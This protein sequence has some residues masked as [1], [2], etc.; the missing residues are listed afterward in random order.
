NSEADFSAN[1]SSNS[2]LITDTAANIRRIVQIVSA[3]DTH[4]A[5]A[6]DYRVL[7]LQYA[8]ATTTA[9]LIN[10]L[11]GDQNQRN[12][13]QGGGGGNPFFGG[14]GGFGGGGF[15]GGGFGGGGRGGGGG[16]GGGGGGGGNRGQG[17]QD[18]NARQT[19]RANAV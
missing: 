3:L 2:L 4:L 11:F 13:N 10:Q 1:A 6:L 7:Q 15:G 5:D 14:F 16:N 8:S 18:Q 9:N 19:A 12:R 17:N